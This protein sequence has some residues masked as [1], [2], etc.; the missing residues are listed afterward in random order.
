MSDF[1]KGAIVGGV[2]GIWIGVIIICLM[3]MAGKT[4]RELGE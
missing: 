3:S 4:S 2:A 1:I